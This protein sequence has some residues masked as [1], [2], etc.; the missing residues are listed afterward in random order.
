MDITLEG[1][2]KD[3]PTYGMQFK[4]NSSEVQENDFVG[5]IS[6]LSSSNFKGIG[7]SV[8]SSIVSKYG[9]KTL[10]II[11]NTPWDLTEIK[12]ITSSKVNDI[13]E[14]HMENKA[15]LPLYELFKG[16]ITEYQV[17]TILLTYGEKSVDVIKMDPYKLI[18]DIDGFGFKRVDNLALNMGIKKDSDVRV[19]AAIEHTLSEWKEFGHLFGQLDS[20]M[21]TIERLTGKLTDEN[22]QERRRNESR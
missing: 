1:E 9:D 7:P 22:R 21:D 5:L 13:Y 4:V 14:A 3:D 16:Q 17:K 12:G 2:F 19:G 8:A 15:E 6:Y 10:D 18:R 11:E 20:L